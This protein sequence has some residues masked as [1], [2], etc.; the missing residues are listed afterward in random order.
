MR[1]I[2]LIITMVIG[3]FGFS[4]DESNKKAVEFKTDFRLNQVRFEAEKSLFRLE[5]P[6]HTLL[7]IRPNGVELLEGAVIPLHEG[8]T[9]TPSIGGVYFYNT[10]EIDFRFRGSLKVDYDRLYIKIN[11]GS[12]W[13]EH[14]VTTKIAYGLIGDRLQF[15]IASINENV[16]PLLRMKMYIGNRKPKTFGIQCSFIKNQFRYSIKLDINEWI[17]PNK[18]PFRKKKK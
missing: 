12:D 18:N 4:Q 14:D 13:L 3:L 9:F 10:K 7:I 16:G 8:I 6:L 2:I 1:K 5:I 11:Y 17:H 15:G